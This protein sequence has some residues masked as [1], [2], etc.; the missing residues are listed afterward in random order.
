MDIFKTVDG[1][2]IIQNENCVIMS[3]SSIQPELEE[4]WQKAREIGSGADLTTMDTALATMDM[5]AV[6]RLDQKSVDFEDRMCQISKTWEYFFRGA[7]IHGEESD[8]GVPDIRK[9]PFYRRIKLI[10]RN[11]YQDA[12]PES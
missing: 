7:T 12:A 11:D 10:Y 8:I 1:E 6:Q 3:C 9:D 4:I 2:W 5:A